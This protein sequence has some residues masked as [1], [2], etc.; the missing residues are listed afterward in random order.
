MC[1]VLTAKSN[2]L[3]AKFFFVEIIFSAKILFVCFYYKHG[4]QKDIVFPVREWIVYVRQT[5]FLHYVYKHLF[6][7]HFIVM[8]LLEFLACA[9]R[10]E[11][12]GLA[13]LQSC[14]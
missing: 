3:T 7:K 11:N 2:R 12:I 10:D 8:Q 4:R 5:N 14:F 9:R 1:E 13:T 6:R